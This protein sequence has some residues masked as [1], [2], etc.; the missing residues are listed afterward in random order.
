MEFDSRTVIENQHILCHFRYELINKKKSLQAGS[1]FLKI[2]NEVNRWR[3][4]LH[5]TANS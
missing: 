4:R 1:G 2:I 3:C 5:K